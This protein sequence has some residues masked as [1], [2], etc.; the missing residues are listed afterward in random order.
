M[1]NI[2]VNSQNISYTSEEIN[3]KYI[4]ET[5]KVNK[6]KDGITVTP[7]EVPVHFKV[8]RNVP[9]V[10]VMLVGWGGNNG[11]TFTGAYLANKYKISWETKTGTKQP[12]W[13]GS[14]LQSSTVSL[15]FS[16]DGE[17]YVPMHEM[18]PMVNPNNL[19]ID[20]WDISSMSIKDAMRRAEVFDFDLQQKL[21]PYMDNMTPRRSI[22]RKDFIAANQAERADNVIIGTTE[23]QLMTIRN[24]IKDFKDKNNLDNV[25]VLWTANTERF[26][27][28]IPGIHDTSENLLNAIARNESEISA[29]SLFA[30]ASILEGSAYINGSPQNT[31]VPGIIQLAEEHRVFLG[32]DDFKSGQTKIKSVLVDFLVS[33]G[34]KPVSIVSYNHLGNNDGKNLSAPKQ[35]R[36]KEISKSN[37]VDDMVESNQVLYSPG[38]KPDHVVVIKYVPYVSDSKRAMDEY[39]S[40]IMMNGTNTIVAHNTC[41][42]SLLATPI[43]LDLVLLTD[44]CQRITMKIGKSEEYQGF[45]SIL[46]LLSYLLKAPLV[47]K[48]TPIVNALFKQRA[49]IENIL[50]ACLSLPPQN[51]MQLEF[52]LA[53]SSVFKREMTQQTAITQEKNNICNGNIKEINGH[54]K[55]QNGQ[56]ILNGYPNFNNKYE[57]NGFR[58]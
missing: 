1:A 17:V 12:N 29:S 41:E 33:A 51:H 58:H 4:Y 49:A 38:E 52:R 20:G 31:F 46:S 18:L 14:V 3:S 50:R 8:K 57:I 55:V 7:T 54:V 13:F 45:N 43:I 26:C 10:G 36:S 6:H 21:S 30:I 5:T 44:L 37:V 35:F 48:G 25:I 27:D 16:D 19:V 15:G 2:I 56:A 11:T 22:Y 9:K 34:I 47:P 42:D 53:D 39:T 32:G 40:E 28:I 24:D 23:E